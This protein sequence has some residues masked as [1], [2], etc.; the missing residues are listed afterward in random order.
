MLYKTPIGMPTY[1]LVSYLR[2]EC[3]CYNN[4]SH[5]VFNHDLVQRTVLL[6]LSLVFFAV[7]MNRRAKKKYHPHDIS[8]KLD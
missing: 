8:S 1:L 7:T 2:T 5:F 6:F 3:K 4:Y